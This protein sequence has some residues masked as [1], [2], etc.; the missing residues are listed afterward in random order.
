MTSHQCGWTASLAIDC[1]LIQMCSQIE[2][3]STVVTNKIQTI[4]FW[5]PINQNKIKM[6]VFCVPTPTMASMCVFNNALY[7]KDFS[8]RAHFL[9]S[10]ERAMVSPQSD[11][12]NASSSHN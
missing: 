7:M 4:A 3:L 12:E 2:H 9:L 10:L 11:R 1:V 8:Q 6:M 5:C